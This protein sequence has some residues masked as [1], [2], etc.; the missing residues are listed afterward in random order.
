MKVTGWSNG[1]EVY[2]VRV[3]TVDRDA[4]FDR[5]W[6]SVTLRLDGRR[7]CVGITPSFWRCCTELR[8][9]EIGEYMLANGLAPWPKGKPP[10]FDLVPVHDAALHS[11]GCGRIL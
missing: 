8:S 3:S 7:V 1:G 5:Q 11:C 10:I 2:G 6:K 4:H 9:K